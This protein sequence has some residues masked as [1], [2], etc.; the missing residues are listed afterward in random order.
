MFVKLTSGPYPLSSGYTVVV[1][2][3]D[4]RYPL[5]HR[6]FDLRCQPLRRHSAAPRRLIAHELA[7]ISGSATPSPPGAGDT[8]GCTRASPA[9]PNGCGPSTRGPQRRR[10]GPSTTTSGWP[11]S[12]A[13]SACW[14]TRDRATCL[15]TACTNAARSRSTCYG[16]ASAT[17]FLCAATDWTTRH[18]HSTRVTDDFTG[19][20]S[21]LTHR[22]RCDP[23]G[24]PGCTR[25]RCHRRDRRGNAP[26]PITRGSVTRVGTATVL[27]AL[28]GYAVLYLA[29]AR[30]RAGGLLGVRARSGARSVWSPAPRYGLLQE[31]TCEVRSARY[32]EVVDGPRTHPMRVAAMVGMRARRGDRREFA[33]VVGACVRPVAVVECGAAERRAGRRS[34]C[35]PR[36]RGACWPG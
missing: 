8:S 24:M 34:A 36:L 16:G 25:K 4:L 20:A 3:D 19:L 31:A 22:V 29:A 18:R 11:N 15:T 1:T 14:P 32:T 17:T 33:A 13:G 30:S 10:V 27:S 7:R 12:P 35:T 9:T 26:G 28:C 21:Q 6:D 5:R 2:D 23:S